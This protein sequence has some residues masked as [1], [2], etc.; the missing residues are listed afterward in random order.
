MAKPYFTLQQAAEIAEFKTASMVDY[1]CRSG[2]VVPSAL[3]SPGRGRKRLY[4]LGD[5]IVLRAL[6][7]LLKSGL[8]VSRLKKG[9]QTLRKRLKNQRPDS[10]IVKYL[11]TDG[12]SVFFEDDPGVFTDLT[13]DGQMAFAFIVD[14]SQAKA[15][16][17]RK[18]SA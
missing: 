18:M 12:R 9:L 7:R 15:D 16:V 1:L 6:N 14:L 2:I 5:L 8:P 4:T 10:A 11:I 13:A 3:S 17:L